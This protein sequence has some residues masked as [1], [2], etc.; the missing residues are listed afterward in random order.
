MIYAKGSRRNV[1]FFS[2]CKNI[3][4]IDMLP[5]LRSRAAGRT[6]QYRGYFSDLRC[7]KQDMQSLIPTN[8]VT[9]CLHLS[10]CLSDL[11]FVS[12]PWP[13]Q[14][15]TMYIPLHAVSVILN[16]D[17]FLYRHNLDTSQWQT[18][19]ACSRSSWPRGAYTV[20]IKTSH[21]PGFTWTECVPNST[22]R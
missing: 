14:T 3:V 19:S 1:Y 10:S 16:T 18:S 8:F 2:C 11:Q 17:T 22:R 12:R 20:H 6:S 13:M 9:D 7:S 15:I 4:C 5:I 21:L